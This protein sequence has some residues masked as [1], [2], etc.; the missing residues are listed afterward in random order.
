M[1]ILNIYKCVC[2][3]FCEQFISFN[4]LFWKKLQ[5]VI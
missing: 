5:N 4:E 2:V 3:L 1:Q